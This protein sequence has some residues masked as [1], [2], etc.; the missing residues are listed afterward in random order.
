MEES[1]G[2]S[3]DFQRVRLSGKLR[4]FSGSS[5]VFRQ[6]RGF[7][8]DCSGGAIGG[9]D[10][11]RLDEPDLMVVTTQPTVTAMAVGASAESGRTV[12]R[13]NRAHGRPQWR[14]WVEGNRRG[15]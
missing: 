8:G 13:S 4:R 10:R 6:F 5:G 1:D 14:R 2:K 9:K 12:G 7:S 11:L 3:D 15:S